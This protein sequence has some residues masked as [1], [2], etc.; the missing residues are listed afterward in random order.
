MHH[1]GFGGLG[2]SCLHG[3]G[4]P[5]ALTSDSIPLGLIIGLIALVVIAIVIIIIAIVALRRH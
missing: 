5:L 1:F 2:G 4:S 3:C